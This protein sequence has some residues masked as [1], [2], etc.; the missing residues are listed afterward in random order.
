MK[1]LLYFLLITTLTISTLTTHAQIISTL[2]GTV[3]SGYSGDH[4]PATSAQ[5]FHPKGCAIDDTGNV[6]IADADNN[7]IRKVSPTGVI[8]TI[9]G[10]PAGGFSGDNGP[11]EFAGLSRPNSICIDRFHNIYICDADNQRIRKI[12][13]GGIIHTIAG[14]GTA[15]FFGD[16]G[17][18]TASEIN[19]PG[20][21]ALDRKG[22]LYITDEYNN[23]IRKIDTG[24]NISTIAGNGSLGYPGDLERADTAAIG[25]PFGI[26]TDSIGNV[27]FSLTLDN[28][29]CK[30]DTAGM[31]TSV[32]GI[33]GGTGGFGG[34]GGPATAA[35]FD[36]PWGIDVDDTG[37]IYIAD[38]A[39]ERI[40]KVTA[41]TGYI[42]TVAGNGSAGFF[43][44]GSPAIAAKIK[45]PAGVNIDRHGNLY[46]ADYNNHRVRKVTDTTH[47]PALGVNV[48]IWN[49][50][51]AIYPNPSS[52]KFTVYISTPAEEQAAIG[53]TNVLGEKVRDFHVAT[54]KP[55]EMQID[56]P[57]GIYS[58]SIESN[59]IHANR[60]VSITR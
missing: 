42:S 60:S 16:G 48:A 27:Y 43:G 59:S 19:Y 51:V 12:D 28:R 38:N 37:N 53:V 2:A 35:Q 45:D 46:I 8:T 41:S 58:V 11:A 23:R 18:A 32:A 4:G 26:G 33:G 31:I 5:L 3:A 6:Y 57:A 55:F 14:D 24:G 17:P 22:N 7:V 10:Y 25:F 56:A 20:G 54:N 50:G 15:A 44:D 52:G 47:V 39:N 21:I 1:K 49:T 13:T 30:V 36:N 34:D 29:I 40:R 9:C